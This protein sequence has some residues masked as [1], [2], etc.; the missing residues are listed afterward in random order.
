MRQSP[1]FTPLDVGS[2]TLSNRIT[3]PPMCQ[4]QAKD[5]K[6]STWHLV[7]YGKLAG[8]GASLV[9]IESVGVAK[10][11]RIT[12]GCLG[13]WDDEQV[14][15]FA[16][17]IRT[18][19]AINPDIKVMVQL[20]HSGRK[21]SHDVQWVGKLLS[22]QEGGWV[23][24]SASAIS[25]GG[26]YPVPEM[27]SKDD[28]DAVVEAYAKAAA[29]AQAAGVDSIQLHAAHGY[30][31]HQFLS[32]ISNQR[33]DEYGGSLENRMRMPLRVFEA[34]KKAA[35]DV[36]LGVRVSA[37]DWI[38][39]GWNEADTIAFVN[40][41]KPLGC[42]FVDVSTGGLAE[43]QAVPVAYGY[44]LKFA[45]QIKDAC[46]LTT[47]G[48]GLIKDARQAESAIVEGSCDAVGIGRQMLL[49]PHWG[50][51]AALELGVDV[52]FPPSYKRGM[53]L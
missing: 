13:L 22:P 42:E 17:V 16:E 2:M 31:V 30:L 26:A 4:Y 45:R 10:E 40:A 14:E 19:R 8:S 23:L 11:G 35:P 25:A 7:H 47:F 9:C 51:R 24:K 34:M 32:P 5:G 1:L 46:G 38:E 44:Q 52:E 20:N 28:I 15:P 12:I 50:W 41:L 43:H 49:D 39:G 6:P 29:R 37:T 21:G 36:V 48:V 53:H 18:M 27:M 3:V 33:D